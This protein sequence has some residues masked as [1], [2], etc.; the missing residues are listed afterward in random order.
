MSILPHITTTPHTPSEAE[1]LARNVHVQLS[2]TIRRRRSEDGEVA[3]ES[4]LASIHPDRLVLTT[5]DESGLSSHETVPIDIETHLAQGGDDPAMSSPLTIDVKKRLGHG[6]FETIAR[7]H[8]TASF[9]W[10]VRS[11][12]P[13]ILGFLG[14]TYRFEGVQDLTFER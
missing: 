13:R 10:L 4:V 2:W 3:V 14:G 11:D 12:I 9:Q 8:R 7:L 6:R 5:T 1:T